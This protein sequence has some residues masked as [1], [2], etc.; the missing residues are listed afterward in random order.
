MGWTAVAL[1]TFLIAVGISIRCIKEETR[2]EVVPT[3]IL[4][5][6][7][8]PEFIAQ[9]P[10]YLSVY[11]NKTPYVALPDAEVTFDVLKNIPA[12]IALFSDGS[13]IGIYLRLRVSHINA[14]PSY[15]RTRKLRDGEQDDMKVSSQEPFI[16][17]A[18]AWPHSNKEWLLNAESCPRL[19]H[20]GAPFDKENV[21]EQ[22]HFSCDPGET[23]EK[24]TIDGF[25][26][27]Q[28]QDQLPPKNQHHLAWVLLRLLTKGSLRIRERRTD[29]LYTSFE[30]PAVGYWQISIDR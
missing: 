5:K 12:P 29:L 8:P 25:I 21:I 24:E 1:G 30:K 4:Q 14:D 7:A 19:E 13:R 28:C 15:D 9:L 23:L 26:N 20:R 17:H 16:L 22:N 3:V 6:C 27:E 2:T 10:E 11:V 18:L